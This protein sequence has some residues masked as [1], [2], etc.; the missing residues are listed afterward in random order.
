LLN[1]QCLQNDWF[2]KRSQIVA[3]GLRKYQP[4]VG[5]LDL[6]SERSTGIELRLFSIRIAIILI[7]IGL[8]MNFRTEEQSMKMAL[9]THCDE[10]AAS[11]APSSYVTFYV[12][13]RDKRRAL[14]RPPSA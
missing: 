6:R 1:L 10:Y 14:I 13:L 11:P 7:N 2:N 5:Y 8:T 12:T 3:A 9:G 4:D